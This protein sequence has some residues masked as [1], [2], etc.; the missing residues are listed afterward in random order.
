MF[1]TECD[2][3]YMDQAL[4]K[5]RNELVDEMAGLPER[6]ESDIL[7]LRSDIT[8]LKAAK[9]LDGLVE[10]ETAE[11]ALKAINTAISFARYMEQRLE[12]ESQDK[13]LLNW[14]LNSAFEKT[15][16]V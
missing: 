14:D 1:A 8:L 6:A 4:I 3:K 10:S 13:G 5:V 2:R 7:K 11:V 15:T 9:K 12:R 16:S